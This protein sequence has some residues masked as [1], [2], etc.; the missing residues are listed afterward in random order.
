V[1]LRGLR[2]ELGEIESVIAQQEGVGQVV[3]MIRKING[4][5]HLCAY[6]TANHAVDI[7]ELKVEIGKSLTQYMVPTAYLQLDKM[8]TTPSGKTDMKALPEPTLSITTAYVAP[9]NE[10]EQQLC[11]IFANILQVER[12]GATDD[13][14]ELG[15][16]SL[17]VTRLIIDVD[18]I[19]HHLVYGDVFDNPTPQQIAAL[20]TGTQ[21]TERVSLESEVKDFDYTAIDKV[22][23]G[24]TLDAFMQGTPLALGH[25]LLT[26]ATGFLGIHL[27]YELINSDATTIT[28]LVRSE[29]QEGAQKRL[30]TLLYYY[31]ASSFND[32]F[33]SGRLRVIKGDVTDDLCA[34]CGDADLTTVINCAAIVKHFSKDNDI[35]HVNVDGTERCVDLCQ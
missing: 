30:Q 12:V 34:I 11:D 33:E 1:K 20:L 19:G 31:F 5:E 27:V 14:F 10:L 4:K 13:F 6:F 21:V 28:C 8:P 7:D 2:I 9:A 26:G 32:L 24:G 29:S 35:E 25:V 17:V 15:G 18:K 3:V 16:T 23:T 22:L